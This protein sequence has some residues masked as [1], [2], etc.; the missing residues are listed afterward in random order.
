M[1]TRSGERRRACVVIGTSLRAARD[2]NQVRRASPELWVDWGKFGLRAACDGNQ[3]RSCNGRRQPS[4]L[5]GNRG[6]FECGAQ[7]GYKVGRASWGS[8]S[9]CGRLE[10]GTVVTKS[11]ERNMGC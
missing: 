3:V 1:V 2:G 10:C 8:R 5:K 9:N 6:S 11:G 4:D 7:Y